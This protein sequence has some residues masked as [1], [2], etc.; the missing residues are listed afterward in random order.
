MLNDH[1][2]LLPWFCQIVIYALWLLL[3]IKLFKLTIKR[4]YLAVIIT[5]FILT[6]LSQSI[7]MNGSQLILKSGIFALIEVG[8][9]I[10][11]FVNNLA[12]YILFLLSI[13]TLVWSVV[14]CL[15]L[16]VS[17]TK[18]TSKWSIVGWIVGAILISAISTYLSLAY[19]H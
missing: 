13:P 6:F 3:A 17:E 12:Y 10:P 15:L 16:S 18:T 19:V 2:S 1:I 7:A 14:L 9:I 8:K 4:S 11:A 5:A